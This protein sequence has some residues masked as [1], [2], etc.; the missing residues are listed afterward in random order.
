M[1][2]QAVLGS[3]ERFLAMLLEHYRGRLPL[4]LAPDQLVVASIG[5]AQAAYAARV[6]YAFQQH[7]FRVALD[8]RPERL[9]RKIVDAREAG[10]PVLIAVGAREDK[11]GTVS[12][13]RDGEQTILPV[14]EAILRLRPD[15]FPSP[16]QWERA[17]VRA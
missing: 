9:S 13:R 14:D 17:R 15:A 8:V 4:W 1:I 2:H 12:L 10:I 6:S 11:A 7:D 3:L 16:T 5:E